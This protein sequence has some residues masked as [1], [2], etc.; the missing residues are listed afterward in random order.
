MT[1]TIKTDA[2][3]RRITHA[4]CAR[5]RNKTLLNDI[6]PFQCRAC[7]VTARMC[8]EC[9]RKALHRDRSLCYECKATQAEMMI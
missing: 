1:T 6:C 8:R 5:C 4:T 2:T 3:T 7:K 9:H